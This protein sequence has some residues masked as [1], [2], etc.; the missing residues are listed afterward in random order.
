V[1]AHAQAPVPPQRHFR[2]VM[3]TGIGYSAAIPD[4]VLGASVYRFLGSGSLGVFADWKMKANSLKGS[5]NY[6]PSVIQSCQVAWVEAERN[7]IRIR[8]EDEWLLFNVGVI[9]AFTPE[10]AL[11]LGGGPA[12]K[13]RITEFFHD[14]PDDNLR[15]TETGGYFVNDDPSSGWTGQVAVGG[16]LRAGNG[17]AFRIGYETAPGGMSV[18]AYWAFR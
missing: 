9:Y 13:T 5:D 4:A 12:R 2:A 15:I 6:C 17:L 7:D 1:P 10:F 14:E 11:M 8:D 18:G 3:R 16:M